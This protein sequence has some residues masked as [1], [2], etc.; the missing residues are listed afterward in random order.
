MAAHEDRMA[1]LLRG[2]RRDGVGGGL[3]PYQRQLLAMAYAALDET[4]EGYA[5]PRGGEIY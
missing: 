1:V 3:S 2:G 4:W 5:V